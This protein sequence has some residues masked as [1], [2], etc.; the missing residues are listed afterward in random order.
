LAGDVRRAA[1]FALTLFKTKEL[2]MASED[3]D[4]PPAQKSG[5]EKWYTDQFVIAI[6][7]S[8]C[9]GIIGL[10]VNVIGF[11]VVKD[12]K[13]KSNATICMVISLI[14]VGIAVVVNVMGGFANLANR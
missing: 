10:I 9:C 7:V 2:L 3:Y 4:A 13:A 6:I 1:F 5:M 8:I 14:L 12:P 11:F